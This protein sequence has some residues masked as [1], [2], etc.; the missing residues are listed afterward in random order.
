MVWD[1]KNLWGA[2]IRH[3]SEHV[4]KSTK[5]GKIAYFHD[6]NWW[7]SKFVAWYKCNK[8]NIRN[9]TLCIYL[10]NFNIIIITSENRKKNFGDFDAIGGVV[11]I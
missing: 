2:H 3:I 1:K 11:E 8:K 7:L 9:K 5:S 6:Q 10:K 4:K